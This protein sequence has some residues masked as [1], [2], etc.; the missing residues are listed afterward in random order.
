MNFSFFIAKRYFFSG[1]TKTAVNIIS[2]VSLIGISIGTAA[3]VL[4]LSVF[5]GFE[6]LLLSMYNAFD[7]H[8]KITSVE[9]K[10]FD[11]DAVNNFLNEHE[12]ILYFTDVLEEKVLMK[13]GDNEFIATIKGVGD[14]FT[15]MTNLDSIIVEGE[16]LASY[17]NK[18]VAILGQGVSY[19]LSIGVGNMF[20]RLKIFVPNRES[21]TLLNPSKA[22]SSASVLPIGIFR[23]G[24]EYDTKYIITPIAFLQDLLQQKEVSAIEIKLKENHKMLGVQ[25]RLKEQLGEKYLVQNR[26]QQHVFLYKVLNSER[27][28]VFLILVFMILIATFNIIGSL[29]MLMIEKKS[30]IQT[31]RNLG[32]TQKDIQRIFFTEGILTIIIGSC[33]GMLLGL[34]LAFVQMK[35]GIIGMGEGN[36]IISSYP[37]AIRFMDLIWVQITV[38]II[39]LLASYYPA[40]I[41]SK[42]L[43]KT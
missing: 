9:G 15:K 7:P 24:A 11:A 1:K 25:K 8:L 29:S 10:T 34:L 31:L 3:L 37:V 6:N 36:F 41:L 38:L 33:I 35:Y 40:K 43:I 23:L 30:D 28:G 18:S 27:L 14:H 4:L 17:Q 32:S 13:N 16:S 21:T 26:L 20:N 19:H 42:R 5:N 39:G 12:D 22:F 2:L